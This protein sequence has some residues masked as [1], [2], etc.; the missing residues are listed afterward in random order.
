MTTP[1][2]TLVLEAA[3]AR[4]DAADHTVHDIQIP[5]NRRSDAADAQHEQ[6]AEAAVLHA[7]V[8]PNCTR[9]ERRV[10]CN[11]V[12]R[13][14]VHSTNGFNDSSVQTPGLQGAAY[15]LSFNIYSH[16]PAVAFNLPIF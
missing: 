8:L 10:H 3:E 6:P 13:N 11:S 9:R 2:A 1:N 15:S 16:M 5:S 12:I 7:V 4:S 14:L